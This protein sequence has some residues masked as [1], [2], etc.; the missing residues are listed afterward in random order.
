MSKIL[1]YFTKEDVQ[2]QQD[3]NNIHL[4][5]ANLKPQLSTSLMVQ[6]LGIHLPMQET[7][8]QTLVQEDSRC[9]EAMKPMHL[10]YWAREARL[11]KPEH[12]RACAPQEKSPQW[13]ARTL[14]LKS[15]LHSR[16]LEKPTRSDGDPAQPERNTVLKKENH[17]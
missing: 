15:S 9:C 1:K 2:I 6:W 11:P 3:L 10:N 17:N 12:S 4:K 16:Q 8:V 13:E 5:N 14:R 7:R